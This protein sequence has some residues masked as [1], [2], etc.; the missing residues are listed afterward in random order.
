MLANMFASAV[1]RGIQLLDSARPG[2]DEKIDVTRLDISSGTMC[3]C[4][5]LAAEEN[6][7]PGPGDNRGFSAMLVAL[8]V[9]SAAEQGAYVIA[10]VHNTSAL[11]N[12]R[13]LHRA[14]FY[15]FALDGS[16][17]RDHK[18]DY[19]LLRS[20]WVSRIEARR[21]MRAA[22]QTI[23]QEAVLEPELVHA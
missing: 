19:A 5:Q 10:F 3:I 14:A 8:G 2:W 22:L 16:R 9:V 1:E 21:L 23:S 17:S 20:E 18:L 6:L 7:P 11:S 4:G 15:G 13:L 12:S